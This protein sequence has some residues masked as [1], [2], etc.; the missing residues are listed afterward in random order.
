MHRLLKKNHTTESAWPLGV[1]WLGPISAFRPIT[2]EN[3]KPLTQQIGP[4]SRCKAAL[5]V[6]IDVAVGSPC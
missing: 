2:S 5:I 3:L 1:K 4:T 6:I